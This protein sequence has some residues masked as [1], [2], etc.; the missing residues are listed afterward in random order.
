MI[1]NDNRVLR[2]LKSWRYAQ[3]NLQT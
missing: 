1:R 3:L 2:E